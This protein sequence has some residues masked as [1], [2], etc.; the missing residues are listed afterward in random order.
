M[1]E[2]ELAGNRMSVLSVCTRSGVGEGL[3]RGGGDAPLTLWATLPSSS[4]S[5]AS[6]PPSKL[7][8]F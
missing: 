5:S 3:I 2:Q 8:T 4:S 7:S 1:R 6:A